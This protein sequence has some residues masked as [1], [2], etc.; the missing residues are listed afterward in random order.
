MTGDYELLEHPEE[1][2]DI[3]ESLPDAT[4][5]IDKSGK[6]LFW[7][8]EM[9]K[10][11]G[12]PGREMVGKGNYEY[13]LPFYGTRR[14][15]LLDMIVDPN[16][17]FGAEY[18]YIQRDGDILTTET[19]IGKLRGQTRVLW[20]RAAPLHNRQGQLVGAIETVRDVT[21]RKMVEEQLRDSQRQLAD[22]IESLPDGTGVVD[23]TGTIT[24]W[25]RAMEELTGYRSEVMVGKGNYEFAIP[26]YGYR[27]PVLLNYVLD[28]T[29]DIN[30]EY[31]YIHSADNVWYIEAKTDKLR[32]K[33][34][35][36]WARA[37]PLYDR[38]GNIVGAIETVRDVTD[39][40]RME[41]DLRDSQRQLADIIE[42][43]P[44]GTCVVDREG[45]IMYWNRAMEELTGYQS[46]VMVGKGNYEFAIPF[47]GY[48]RPVLLNYIL[49]P[50]INISKEYS[51]I[52]SADNVWYIEAKTDKLRGKEAY[53]WA[54]ATPLYDRDGNIA[55]AIESVR[56]VT[57]RK[58]AEKELAD[59][60]RQLADTIESLPD[61]TFVID[62]NGIILQWNQEIAKMTGC[63]AQD[64]VGKGNYEYSIPFYRGI[65]RPM[66][67]DMIIH[68]DL[69]I[70]DMYINLRR[71]GEVIVIEDN[72]AYPR[73]AEKVVWGR[74][75]PL[76]NS[77]GQ[78]IGAIQTIR[79]FTERKKAEDEIQR[80]HQQLEEVFDG[81]V[82][83]LA[84][85]TE[86]RDRYT[87]GH[88]QRVAALSVMIAREMGLDEHTVHHL[89]IAAS[90]HDIGKLYIPLDI[91][92]Q[93]S[94]LNDIQKLLVMNHSE[95]GYDMVKNIPFEGPIAQ[96]IE[97]H[98]ERLDG[99]GYPLGIKGD[100]ILLEAKILAV[101]D[102]VEAMAAARPYRPAL[103]I[104][105]ALDE[106]QTNAGKL[107]DPA[108]VEVCAKILK[109]NRFQFSTGM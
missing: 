29:T 54:R 31:S 84:I 8:R 25:N 64:M 14:P 12:F 5:V 59:S 60:Q 4:L 71:E 13:A 30:K 44:D 105:K 92:S 17:H 52:H 51:Y 98:H 26:F 3:I 41:E 77:D 94:R 40:R 91:L 70:S 20:G 108:V 47:Y 57:E 42:S 81:T 33:E 79:D 27:R 2:S 49:D 99:S 104:E 32:G 97:Q 23:R 107:Y 38:D 87:S 61:A 65:R 86:K 21:E 1:L 80:S 7:N 53:I 82:H 43:L 45:K 73:G 56:D 37:T 66:I 16:V 67:V 68:P 24:H 85:T 22:I 28:P 62:N 15:I 89:N 74:A 6:I 78:V 58:R 55:G 36:I 106:I 9:A 48:R 83:A 50:N 63:T 19:T 75:A 34:A 35:I 109:E 93:P 76:Y 39:R 95:A 96:I 100:Q 69:D 72:I 46:E 18:V 90:L 10:L 101:A 103:G 11:T 102:T 88:Q